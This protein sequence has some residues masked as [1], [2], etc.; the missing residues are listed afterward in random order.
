MIVSRDLTTIVAPCGA[1]R[2]FI[3]E[4]GL[5]WTVVMIKSKEEQQICTVKD[6]L[7]F[8][9]DSTSL[10]LNELNNNNVVTKDNNLNLTS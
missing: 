1:C 8:A 2:Q 5:D 6:I 7:P 10:A 9:F 3:A 4:F